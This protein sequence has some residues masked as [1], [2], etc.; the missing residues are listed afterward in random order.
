MIKFYDVIL[1]IAAP[2][3]K[4]WA[5]IHSPY[6]R[7]KINGTHYYKIRDKIKI[8][9]VFVTKTNG[10]FSN[11]INP[12]ELKHAAIYVGRISNSEI[13][14]V[15]EAVGRGVVLTDLVSFL[16]SKDIVVQCK[17]KFIRQDL[18]SFEYNI[19][20]Y[21]QK[22]IGLPYDYLFNKDGKAFY[23]FELCAEALKYVY[24][25]LRLECVE[26]IKAKRI[27][28]HNTFL[29]EKFFEIVFDSREN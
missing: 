23:C 1:T 8:G 17:P 28:D 24:A 22:V 14:Y 7:K 5:K 16:T 9:D 18:K 26:I 29:D 25:E 21:I 2:I 10:E 27:Y 4:I 3:V 15:A 12:A 20:D 6:S 13:C 19:Q 11:I